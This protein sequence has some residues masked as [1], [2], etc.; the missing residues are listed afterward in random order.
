[1]LLRIRNAMLKVYC[2][3]VLS[4][5]TFLATPVSAAATTTPPEGA[6]ISIELVD[7]EGAFG[8]SAATVAEA[9]S[10]VFAGK[11][12]TI[13]QDPVH[14][15]YIA[16]LTLH[17]VEV[18]TG[19]EG[20]PKGK[21]SLFP[22]GNMGGAGAGITVP[23]PTGKS[24]LVPLQRI[25]LDMTIG[26]RGSDGDVWHGAA[27]TVRA[28]GAGRALDVPVARKLSE[29]ALRSYP[30]QTGEVVGVP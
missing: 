2:L 5:L 29:A 17:R 19:S 11:G 23:L 27:V 14:A 26:K 6:T 18:G 7:A 28:L 4:A 25:Q 15:G 1:V 24:S 8:P 22:G 3:A 13:L 12:F 20:V 10:E 30:V 21:A 16:R 9:A